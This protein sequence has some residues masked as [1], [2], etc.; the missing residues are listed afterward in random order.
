MCD[1]MFNREDLYI[2][3]YYIFNLNKIYC[4]KVYFELYI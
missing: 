2:G 1:V 4:E 3:V